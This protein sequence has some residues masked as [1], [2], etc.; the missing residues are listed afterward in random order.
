MGLHVASDVLLRL[1]P[2]FL[3]FGLAARSCPQVNI[4]LLLVK[5]CASAPWVTYI[6]TLDHWMCV[7]LKLLS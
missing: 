5:S 7:A 1:S 4:S 6:F 3:T 2:W